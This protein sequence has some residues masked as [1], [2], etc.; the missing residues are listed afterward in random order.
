MIRNVALI[1]QPFWTT[2]L[3]QLLNEHAPTSIVALPVT[4]WR[5]LANLRK[6]DVFVRVGYRP[7]AS[8]WRGVGFDSLWR[9]A[10]NVLPRTG[11]AYYWIGTDVANACAD[12]RGRRSWRFRTECEQATH[13]AGAPW[14]AD[15]LRAIGVPAIPLLFPGWLPLVS[16][17]PPLPNQLTVATYVPDTRHEFYGSTE[18][19]AVAAAFPDIDFRVFGGQGAWLPSPPKNLHFEGWLDDVAAVYERSTV[20]L[21]LTAHDALGG[22]VREA[23]ALGR[24]VIFSYAVPYTN[25]VRFGDVD[26]LI[27]ALAKLRKSH[28]QGQLSLNTDGALF[29]QAQ[30]NPRT[31]TLSFL[32]AL[33]GCC[34]Q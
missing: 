10:R 14:L 33:N 19:L 25:F 32:A 21:R 6:I 13:F 7:G 8:T 22:T 9:L 11:R 1:G 26:G 16:E 3:A 5:D 31:L 29:A 4:S 28:Q 17:L 27:Q 15:E 30:F 23:L 34:D 20:L 18:I 2:R 12:E 24:H